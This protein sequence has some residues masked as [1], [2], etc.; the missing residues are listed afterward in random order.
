MKVSILRSIMFY[1]EFVF[2]DEPTGGVDPIT[3]RQF[4][5]LIYDAAAR[6]ITIFVTTHY[7]DE[8]EQL[9]DRLMVMD[10]GKI[11]AEG[12]PADLIKKYSSKEVLEVRFGSKNNAEAAKK[13]AHLGDRIE[14]FRLIQ[15]T[16]GF[17]HASLLQLFIGLGARRIR[18]L[19]TRNLPA[20]ALRPRG[21]YAHATAIVQKGTSRLLH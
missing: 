9:C 8:A 17:H 11:M 18:Q 1:P 5:T 20:R 16:T 10:K 7:M 6:G 3:R 4:W 14:P 2:L 13:I 21:K 12:S 19:N 15:I